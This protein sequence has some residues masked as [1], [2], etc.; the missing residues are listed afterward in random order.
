MQTHGRGIPGSRFLGAGCLAVGCNAQDALYAGDRR[1]GRH[2]PTHLRSA[3]R[4]VQSYVLAIERKPGEG[5]LTRFNVVN[6][7]HTVDT[8]GKHVAAVSPAA[9]SLV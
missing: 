7:V 8:P 2:D 1:A 6:T 3:V 5:K 9:V 4:I